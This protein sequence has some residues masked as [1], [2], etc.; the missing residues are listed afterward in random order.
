[1]SYAKFFNPSQTP[2]NEPIPGEAQVEN[3]AGGFLF[4]ID[5][6]TRLD[7]F[8]ILGSDA[9]T[10]YQTPQKLTAEN[11]KVVI[12]CWSADPERTALRIKE[13][14]TN[15]RAPKHGPAIFALALGAIHK[16]ELARQWAYLAVPAVCRTASHLFSWINDCRR[17]GKGW[18][19]G[20]KRVVVR[21]YGERDVNALAYQMVKYRTRVGVNHKNAIELSHKGAGTD[22]QRQALYLWARGKEV[23]ED[24]LPALVQAHL[25]AMRSDNAALLPFISEHKLPW[26][27]LPNTALTDPSVWKAMLPHMGLTA[28]LRNLGNMS[29]CKAINPFDTAAV[30]SRLSVDEVKKSRIHPF[31]ILL[32]QAVYK[33]GRSLRRDKSWSPLPQIIDALDAA[34]YAS[35][36]NVEPTGK[37]IMMAIDVSASM[38]VPLMGALLTCREGAGAL[39]LITMAAEPNTAIYGFTSEGNGNGYG[40]SWGAGELPMIPLAISPRQRLD[41]VCASMKALR[42]GGTDC[43][44][45]MRMATKHDLAVDAFVIITDNETWFGSMHPIQALKEYRRKSGINAKCVVIAMTSTGFSIADPNDSGMLDMVGFDSS[46]PAIMADFIRG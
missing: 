44:L 12:E 26:E 4:Q 8:L 3:N 6:W 23:A 16:D 17:L 33:G 28:L 24:Q 19:R 27:A 10:Y 18:G 9:P 42:A 29:A 13:I 22:A 31:S 5:I 7:R 41:D 20:M 35:F 40:G 34:F 38:E 1:M 30:T 2:Q 45:P 15:G 37:R 21:W 36:S 25:R 39:A 43:S 32:A 11:G 46:G 14:S